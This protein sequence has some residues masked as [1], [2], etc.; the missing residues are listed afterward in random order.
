MIADGTFNIRI[1]VLTIRRKVLLSIVALLTLNYF[2][3]NDIIAAAMTIVA[4]I[5]IL[6]EKMEDA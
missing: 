1:P 4:T 5:A 2:L 3:P 6:S